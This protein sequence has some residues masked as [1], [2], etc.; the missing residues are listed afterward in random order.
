MSQTPTPTALID[1]NGGDHGK[2]KSKLIVFWVAIFRPPEKPS[3]TDSPQI[4]VDV[5]F[6]SVKPFL[7][8]SRIIIASKFASLFLV[9]RGTVAA[10]DRR[11][12]LRSFQMAALC[13]D[14]ATPGYAKL[15]QVTPSYAKLRQVTPSYAKLR[16]LP[17][18]LPLR[19]RNLLFQ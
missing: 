13:R 19:G 6:C 1:G 16:N 4:P 18:T 11:K 15:R 12:L 8:S 14:A 10:A 7:Q 3:K 2:Q 9:R 17:V 5:F